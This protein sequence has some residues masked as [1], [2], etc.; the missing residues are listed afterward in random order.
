VSEWGSGMYGIKHCIL[1]LQVLVS[2][3]AGVREL[4]DDAGRGG[5]RELLDDAGG[6]W[7]GR[8]EGKKFNTVVW[9]HF[10]KTGATLTHSLTHTLTHSLVAFIS[11]FTC[12]THALVSLI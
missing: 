5:V 9:Y 1:L 10:P 8:G 7:L 6:T 12:I 4:L 2:G 11:S 3:A